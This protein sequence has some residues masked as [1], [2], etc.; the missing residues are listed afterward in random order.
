MTQRERIL[1]I[2]DRAKQ[3][4]AVFFFLYLFL[5]FLD[6]VFPG[7][8]SFFLNIHWFLI[9]AGFFAIVTAETVSEKRSEEVPRK[10]L[11]W[12]AALALGVS[13]GAIALLEPFAHTVLWSVTAGLACFLLYLLY[14]FQKS[15]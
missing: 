9:L 3:G 15:I 13:A 12:G 1:F 5:L 10:G 14:Y 7:F 6:L 4:F 2:H 11:F 8:A